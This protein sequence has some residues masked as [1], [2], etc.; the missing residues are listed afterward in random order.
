MDMTIPPEPEVRPVEGVKPSGSAPPSPRSQRGR[1]RDRTE[2]AVV[3]IIATCGGVG[4][5]TAVAAILG[6]QD[7]S[8]WL[9]GLISSLLTLALVALL[10]VRTPARRSHV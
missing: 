6:W 2:S 7:V 9:I 4:I 5:I 8:A 10:W 1:A 3:R